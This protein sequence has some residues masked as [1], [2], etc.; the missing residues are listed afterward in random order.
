[1]STEPTQDPEVVDGD[2]PPVTVPKGTPLSKRLNYYIGR[3]VVVL[4][5]LAAAGSGL[6]VII[7]DLDLTSTVGVIGAV[8]ALAPV[9]IKFLEGVQQHE[10]AGYQ[11]DLQQQKAEAQIQI[12]RAEEEAAAAVGGAQ[13]QSRIAT[14][15]R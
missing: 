8:V 14:P 6:T 10:G 3:V 11:F 5:A 2:G 1:M 13:R 15:G 4:Y 9:L 12:I 7:A